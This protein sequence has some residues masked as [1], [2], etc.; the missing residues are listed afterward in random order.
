MSLNIKK[1]VGIILCI[2]LIITSVFG[3]YY[4]GKQDIHIANSLAHVASEQS[5]PN[6]INTP[7]QRLLV[8]VVENK[9]IREITIF[10]PE[11]ANIGGDV[12]GRKLEQ[13]NISLNGI[14]KP[15]GEA[16]RDGSV[17]F[18]EIAAWAALDADNGFCRESTETKRGL[19]MCRYTYRDFMLTVIND[20][21][22]TPDDQE[23]LIQECTFYPSGVES[24]SIRS[25]VFTDETGAPLDRE[26]W[27]LSLELIE[28]SPSDLTFKVRQSGGQHI[29]NLVTD[30]FSLYCITTET[31]VYSTT[32]EFS[33]ENSGTTVVSL[34]WED[35]CGKLPSGTYSL[36]FGIS[37]IFTEEQR[38][39]LMLDYHDWQTYGLEFT[40]P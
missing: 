4:I 26:D 2:I 30:M 8:S 14:T 16:M 6:Q 28:A 5:I 11:S 7:S 13:V 21:Y 38:H 25:I 40:I 39:P 15:L 34:N 3:G 12:S 29:G 31:D 20:V 24:I 33:I 19:T 9:E 23:H 35:E 10:S 36:V 22:Q 27:G 37:D 1:I 17:S 18:H 32:K